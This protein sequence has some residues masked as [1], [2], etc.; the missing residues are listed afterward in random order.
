MRDVNEKKECVKMFCIFGAQKIFKF[1][2][3][4]R[5]ISTT[6]ENGFTHEF[7]TRRKR[8]KVPIQMSRFVFGLLVLVLAVAVLAVPH[9]RELC[10]GDTG[11]KCIA[12]HFCD[13]GDHCGET[14]VATIFL[15]FHSDDLIRVE[16]SLF[17]LV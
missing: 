16:F 10:E 17:D 11:H 15:F 3:C 1:C 5:R 2:L 14:Y 7:R 12:R 6:S 13:H 8:N 9:G 4:R